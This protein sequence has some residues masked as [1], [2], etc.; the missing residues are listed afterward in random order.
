MAD[1]DDAM[2]D[3][4][5][6]IMTD[7]RAD[8]AARKATRG[9][10]ALRSEISARHEATRGFGYALKQASIAG[11]YG[12]IAEIKKASPSGGLIRLDFD[13]PALARAYAAGGATCLSVLTERTHFQGDPDHLK[14]AL[15]CRMSVFMNGCLNACIF[16]KFANITHKI[17][18]PI[19]KE[20]APN[21]TVFI[22]LFFFLIIKLNFSILKMN[23]IIVENAAI[24]LI[25]LFCA[26]D[27][28]GKFSNNPIGQILN[29]R[30]QKKT[31][32]AIQKFRSL[33]LLSSATDPINDTNKTTSPVY[34]PIA[35]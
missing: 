18:P 4:L 26:C 33:F 10:D 23:I 34:P 14:A 20:I 24:A 15:K 7:V 22:I 5:A 9:I 32:D 19:S 16:V 12:L 2:P 27:N 35:S 11:H 1:Q 28:I 31:E 3:V 21:K 29:V 30:N 6:K 25:L 13:P 8:V 17:T